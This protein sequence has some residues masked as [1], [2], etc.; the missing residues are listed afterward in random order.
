MK[1]RLL[2]LALLAGVQ[3]NAIAQMTLGDMPYWRPYDQRGLNIFET[4]KTDTLGFDGIKV[5]LGGS[6]A[7]QFQALDHTN[8]A[9]GSAGEDSPNKLIKIGNG[10]NLATANLNLD[11]LLADG[12]R[13]NLITYLSSRHHN[14]TWVK[15][16]Y[17][18][19]DKLG[20][21]HHPL[22]DKLMKHLTLRVG[23]MEIN[24]GDGL[25]KD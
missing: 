16:G 18:Q 10:F 2:S 12:I 19:I 21:L 9:T 15:G 22:A 17:L 25:Q 1:K 14:E 4:G 7:Q 8:T 24:Y 13:L 23:H 20:F 6:F 11:V 3:L 5:R